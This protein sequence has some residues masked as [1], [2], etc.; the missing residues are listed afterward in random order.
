MKEVPLRGSEVPSLMSL[1]HD[2]WTSR[3]LGGVES[4]EECCVLIAVRRRRRRAIH[5]PP[6]QTVSLKPLASVC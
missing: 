1:H 4:A 2:T 6:I 3:F 5:N